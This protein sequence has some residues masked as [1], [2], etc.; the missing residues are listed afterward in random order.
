MF[1]DRETAVTHHLV[2]L[3]VTGSG[4]SVFARNLIRQI[5]DDDTKVV[6]VDFTN[7]YGVKLAD[8]IGGSLVKGTQAEAM[9]AAID[10]IS[11]EMDKFAN[12]R[13]KSLVATKENEL[14]DG[15]KIAL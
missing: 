1:I 5:A 12:Q 2:I 11:D 14:R 13:D 4:K 6:C 10:M 7:E 8:L 9:F 3:G 15:F